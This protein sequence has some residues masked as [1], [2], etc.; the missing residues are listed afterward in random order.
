MLLICGLCTSHCL[1]GFCA[2]LCFWYALLC[3]LF[4]FAIILKGKRELVIC[5]FVVL[6]MSYYCKYYVALPYGAVGWSAACDCGIT[7]STHL[8]FY[9]VADF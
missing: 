4:S 7:W 3:V 9:L 2:C 6:R 5:S 1:W 8:H